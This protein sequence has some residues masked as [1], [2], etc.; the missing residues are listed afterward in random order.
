MIN[1]PNSVSDRTL[2][3]ALLYRVLSNS[4]YI[5]KRYHRYPIGGRTLVYL[6]L[7]AYTEGQPRPIDRYAHPACRTNTST[8][9]SARVTQ[10][11]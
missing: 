7:V 3:F 10:L 9:N 2:P 1:E 11:H 4:I 8:T 5:D 6:L